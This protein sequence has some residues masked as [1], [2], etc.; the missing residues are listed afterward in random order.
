MFACVYIH[1]DVH[2]SPK[3]PSGYAAAGVT[4]VVTTCCGCWDLNPARPLKEQQAITTEQPPPVCLKDFM[5]N[6]SFLVPWSA[7]LLSWKVL[8]WQASVCDASLSSLLS[9]FLEIP[10]SYL[11]C[12]ISKIRKTSDYKNQWF[13]KIVCLSQPF[14]ACLVYPPPLFIYLLI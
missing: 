10:F 5:C 1:E 8:P 2:W 13:F 11:H 9:W 14:C 12:W 7:F 4:G 3:R 6:I